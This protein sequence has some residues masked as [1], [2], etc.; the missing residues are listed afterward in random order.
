V[1]VGRG[2]GQDV[3]QD[4]DLL[5]SRKMETLGRLAAGVAHDFNNLLMAITGYADLLLQQITPEDPARASAEE[6]QRVAQRA[7]TL[8]R[9]I[10]CYTHKRS[11]TLQIL[12]L[13]LVVGDIVRM[14]RRL[15]GETVVIDAS[16]EPGLGPIQADLG[17]IEQA[18]M[19]L[20]VNAR[21]AMPGG[22]RLTLTTAQVDCLRGEDD[23][24]SGPWAM[25]SVADTG[26]GMSDRTLSRIFEP[27]Y[28][29][30]GGGGT[31]LG[32]S[33][34]RDVVEGHGGRLEVE[35]HPRGGTTFRLF[36][37]VVGEARLAVSTAPYAAPAYEGAET[38]MVVEDEDSVRRVLAEGLRRAGYTV[39]EARDGEEAL[40]LAEGQ[41]IPIQGVVADLVLPGMPVSEITRRVKP[42]H[43]EARF[44]FVSGYERPPGLYDP[45][46]DR[47]VRFLSKPFS[48]ADLT[49]AVRE[50]LDR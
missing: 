26:C 34:V 43:P 32:L 15:I 16:L 2:E 45:D 40:A 39:L 28:T 48:V 12:D 22:G 14:L 35:S 21:D 42:L 11:R 19:N 3:G 24:D 38:V 47:D 30:K 49:R 4:E 23:A 46:S 29:T 44:V 8:V 17:Q 6:I 20:A 5:Q 1:D 31:G 13:N 25:L 33:I 37:P 9:Q 10:L 50:L 36:F 41:A 7:T 27:F 18:V